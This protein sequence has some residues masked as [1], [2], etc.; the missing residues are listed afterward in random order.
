MKRLISVVV[1][2]LF[3]FG[4]CSKSDDTP[5]PEK[6]TVALTKVKLYW[7]NRDTTQKPDNMDSIM[8]NQIGQVEKIHTNLRDLDVTFAFTYNTKG[9]IIQMHGE[10]NQGLPYEYYFDYNAA[11][12]ISEMRQEFS[13][14]TN[15]YVSKF[16]YT[17]DGKL[18]EIL[19]T[20][21]NFSNPTGYLR[22][23]TKYFRSTKIDSIYTEDV[24]VNSRMITRFPDTTPDKAALTLNKPYV[25]MAAA[26]S[27]LFLNMFSTIS[28]NIFAHQLVNP[29]EI[30]FRDFTTEYYYQ[31]GSVYD[32]EYRTNVKF[33]LN[34][35]AA[36]GRMDYLDISNRATSR[37]LFEYI[38]KKD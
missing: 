38:V 6:T 22:F 1:S 23:H 35:A 31:D 29:D 8:Y 17:N 15:K 18:S 32:P 20:Q 5:V 7:N 10:N 21:S 36:A 26:Q 24:T 19:S 13:N 25:M 9:E 14:Y 12:R 28:S 34:A 11:G 37:Y 30:L 33:T 2:S 16:I 27:A 3:L 4:T